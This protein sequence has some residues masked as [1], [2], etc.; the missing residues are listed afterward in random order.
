MKKNQC[1]FSLYRDETSS[2]EEETED[3]DDKSLPDVPVS[4]SEQNLLEKYIKLY[5]SSKGLS[6]LIELLICMY[7]FS[8]NNVEVETGLKRRQLA[9]QK[10]ANIQERVQEM[11]R[12][13]QRAEQWQRKKR[14]LYIPMTITLGILT[15]GA[16]AYF[17]MKN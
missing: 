5:N 6:L 15:C 13:Q 10:N 7:F 16:I 9:A 3:I 8:S 1:F 14:S 12:K 4:N 17:Y 2:H 11:K